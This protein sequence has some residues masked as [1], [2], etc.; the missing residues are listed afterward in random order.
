MTIR[1]KSR[2]K[3]VRDRLRVLL[4]VL[5]CISATSCASRYQHVSEGSMFNRDGYAQVQVGEDLYQIRYTARGRAG[6][7]GRSPAYEFA[8]YRAAEMAREKKFKGFFVAETQNRQGDNFV[9]TDMTVMMTNTE[10]PGVYDA[11]GV[12]DTIRQEYP[13]YFK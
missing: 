9:V 10:F 4:A 6:L 7:H 3:A 2:V 1:L 13:E 12:V 11:S 8:L 5:V